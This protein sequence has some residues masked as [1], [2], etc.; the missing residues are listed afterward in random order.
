[1]AM[2]ATNARREI[3]DIIWSPSGETINTDGPQPA[4]ATNIV[5]AQHWRASKTPFI[6][7]SYGN[8]STG[9]YVPGLP[10]DENDFAQ[11][12]GNAAW[13]CCYRR[14]ARD[15]VSAVRYRGNAWT[16]S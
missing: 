2:L 15:S 8:T 7:M 10:G 12:R 11:S 16:A 9:K 6:S 3:L 13:T 5:A 1:M 4:G 14:N